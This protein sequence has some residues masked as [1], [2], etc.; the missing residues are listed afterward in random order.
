MAKVSDVILQYQAQN[1]QAQEKVG[2]MIYGMM[3][4]EAQ[5]RREDNWRQWQKQFEAA[6]FG[7]SLAAQKR[8]DDRQ[9][10]RN[11]V[12]EDQANARLAQDKLEFAAGAPMRDANLANVQGQVEGRTFW[13]TAKRRMAE[14]LGEA[15]AGIFGP[16][17]AAQAEAVSKAERKGFIE[18]N[19]EAG[20][21]A[22]GATGGVEERNRQ[23]K[24]AAQNIFSTQIKPMI[25]Q[26]I[27]QSARETE[28]GRKLSSADIA[29]YVNTELLSRMIEE[30]PGA[31]GPAQIPSFWNRGRWAGTGKIVVSPEVAA[32][33]RRLVN[34][35]RE[36]YVKEKMAQTRLERGAK[37]DWMNDL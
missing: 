23:A 30:R 3:V 16:D 22:G 17:K 13:G 25:D 19:V 36:S 18:A 8:D 29:N 7:I 31:P 9:D 35:Y 4:Q 10:A 24:A 28:P 15:A 6:K 34:T 21:P 26:T 27:A 32:E 1:Q 14:G 5:N 33:I 20:L 37:D 12:L 2:Q 11:T